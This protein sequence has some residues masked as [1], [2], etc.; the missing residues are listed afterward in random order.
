LG[1]HFG[2]SLRNRRKEAGMGLRELAA[3]AGLSFTYLAKIER[4]ELA[5]P[6]E[7]KLVR[8]AEV[9]GR[10]SEEF[11]NSAKRLSADVIRIAQR[12]PS[13]YAR[14]LR[15]TKKLSAEE[16][17]GVIDLVVKEVIKIKREKKN[18]TRKS[19]FGGGGGNN[20]L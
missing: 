14:L 4:G 20:G 12:H 17:D 2:V 18:S 7:E 1:Q 13:R 16:L 19:V 9:L 8:L 11:L 5:P 6:S 15:T 3:K 10:S